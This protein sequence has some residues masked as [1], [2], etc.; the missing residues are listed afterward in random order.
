MFLLSGWKKGDR[1]SNEGAIKFFLLGVLSAS[2][3]LYGFSLIYGLT[4][5]LV[6]ADISAY[7]LANS[8]GSSPVLLLSAIL[9]IS[10]I[11]FKI[12]VVP[13]HSWAPDTYEGAPL[14]ITAYLSVSS[15]ATGFVA[16]IV[17]L[18]KVFESSGQSWGVILA[19]V[20]G[21][22]MTLG[23]LVALQQ[24]NPVRLLAYSS[25][26]QAGFIIA[27]LAVSG[28]TGN[29]QDGIF[30]SVTYLIIYAF[31]NIGAFLSVHLFTN[32]TKSDNFYEW[33]GIA[34]HSPLAGV[35]TTVFFFSLAGIPPLGGWFAKFVVFR[36]L[37]STGE[38]IGIFLAIV[39]AIN[40]VIALVYNKW[41]QKS[42]LDFNITEFGSGTGSLIE[43]IKTKNKFA[44]EK[45][46]TARTELS[47]KNIQ[48]ASNLEELTFKN[49]DLVFGNEVLDNIPCSIA[50]YKDGKWQEKIVCFNDGIFSYDFVEARTKTVE[51]I[52]L[53]R[54]KADENIDVE[55]QTNIDIF[56]EKIIRKL[57]PKNILFFDY[58]YE[59]KDRS[60]RKYRSL[61]RTYKDHHLSV[62]PILEPGNVDITYDINF[63]AVI[64]KL[65]TLGYESKLSLQRD[66]LIANGF[67]EYFDNLQNKLLL[68]EG[69]ENLKINSQLSGLKALI[70][71]NGLGG[72]Y[73]LEA[74]KI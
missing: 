29:Y 43:Q 24:T 11:G 4:G 53:N 6:F 25:I 35:L 63:S 44:V 26:S 2:L 23:N 31:M 17:L 66:F 16:L 73:C 39:G 70:D 51:W 69:M 32:F 57:S 15:K 58:G 62:D 40:A 47:Q 68:S 74:K 71:S 5:Q 67:D 27:P 28:I 8:L 12:S 21:A 33:G 56:L 36:S 49:S 41:I 37:L 55:I 18:T 50:V 48:N 61:L 30:A 7:L 65:K 14:P 52:E 20:A 60:K 72:F 45:S 1:K 19:I 10:G 3:I 54:I 42:N 13:F 22:T 46:S 9:V 38:I 34:K 59:Q 64:K